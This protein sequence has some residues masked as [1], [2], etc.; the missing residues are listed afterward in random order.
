MCVC[1]CVCKGRC[2]SYGAGLRFHKSS[3]DRGENWTGIT[4]SQRRVP[5]THGETLPVLTECEKEARR[6]GGPGVMMK[7]ITLKYHFSHGTLLKR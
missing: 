4:V 3:G 7:E 6:T 5:A 1:L 2:A